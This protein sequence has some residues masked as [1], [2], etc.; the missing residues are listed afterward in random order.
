MTTQRAFPFQIPDSVLLDIFAKIKDIHRQAST[1]REWFYSVMLLLDREGEVHFGDLV[2][3]HPSRIIHANGL[4]VISYCKGKVTLSD[5]F[6]NPFI[7]LAHRHCMEKRTMELTEIPI[8]KELDGDSLPYCP[9]VV[10]LG[11]GHIHFGVFAAGSYHDKAIVPR[12]RRLFKLLGMEISFYLFLKRMEEMVQDLLFK[13][14]TEGGNLP[15]FEDLLTFKF[16]QL[17]EKIDPEGSGNILGDVTS[18]VEKILI[19]LAL[20]VTGHKMGQ[21]AKLLGIT[22]NTLR[23]K[24]KTFNVNLVSK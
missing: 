3:T 6:P 2:V 8:E 24:M 21:T 23:K 14:R 5:K 19:R 12:N 9:V 18:L 11:R 10:P 7:A 22:R 20:E 15:D 17:L 4:S 13:E 1:L 16:R